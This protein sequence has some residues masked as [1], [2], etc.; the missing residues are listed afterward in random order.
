MTVPPQSSNIRLR[1][2]TALSDPV[3]LADRGRK[4]TAATSARAQNANPGRQA[5]GAPPTSFADFA[6]R[7]AAAWAMDETR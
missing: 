1:R 2:G 7:T 4:Q 5:T 6:R 3:L